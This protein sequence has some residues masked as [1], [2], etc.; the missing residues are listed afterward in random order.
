MF[1]IALSNFNRFVFGFLVF[2]TLSVVVSSLRARTQH[3]NVRDHQI[4]RYHRASG[5]EVKRAGTCKG[6][7]FTG[8]GV[9]RNLPGFQLI[10][11]L[12]TWRGMAW[13]GVAW[14]VGVMRV[15]VPHTRGEKEKE[16]GGG[17]CPVVARGS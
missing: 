10:A 6:V 11:V 8:S 16:G 9:P 15:R 1:F 5:G 12:R 4:F 13:R 14:R 3:V 17:G 7:L 2:R